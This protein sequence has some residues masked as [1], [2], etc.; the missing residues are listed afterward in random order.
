[1]S[2]IDRG[3]LRQG[4][5]RGVPGQSGDDAGEGDSLLAPVNEFAA[6]QIRRAS[7]SLEDSLESVDAELDNC[8]SAVRLEG[9]RRDVDDE[10]GLCFPCAWLCMVARHFNARHGPMSPS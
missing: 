1:M 6:T 5:G 10:P 3:A 4:L 9:G 2:G 7:I 8:D